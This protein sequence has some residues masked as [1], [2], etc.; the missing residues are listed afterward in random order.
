[1]S[2]SD[3]GATL[4]RRAGIVAAGTLL[5][6]LLGALRDAVI[7]ARFPLVQTDAFVVA[8]TIP[9]ALRQVLGEGAMSAAVVPLVTEAKERRGRDAARDLAGALVGTLGGAAIVVSG[10]GM[11]VAP[12][13]VALYAGGYLE[14]PARFEMAVRLTR[15]LF[16]YLAL[17]SVG[18][19][20][21]GVL[22][23]VGRFGLPA[24]APALLN[25]SLIGAPWLFAPLAVVF[26]GPKVLSL[27]LGALLG[28]CLQVLVLGVGAVRGG[29]VGRV[30]IALGEPVVREAFSRL[31]PLALGLGVYQLNLV[32]SRLLASFLPEGS[33][34]YLYY[35][36][37]LVEVPQ[38]MLA[39]AVAAAS[40]PTLSS[41]GSRGEHEE[42]LRVLRW[43]LRTTWFLALPAAALLFALAEP[44]VA[45][46]FG[47]GHFGSDAIAMTARSLRWQAL[48]VLAVATVRTV[49]PAFHA[50]GE[51]RLPVWASG[52][53]LLVFVAVAV[54]TMGALGHEGIALG[55]SVAA[56]AQLGV[57]LT[58]LRRSVGPLGGRELLGSLGRSLLASVVAAGGAWWVV[59]DEPWALGASG[60]AAMR[61]LGAG[62]LAVLLYLAVARVLRM[63]E[64]GEAWAALSR[65]GGS[66]DGT[67]AA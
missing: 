26:G 60:A 20:V 36:Q 8:F 3:R 50:V 37:R 18:A 13:L 57:L 46:V 40:L 38:G 49:V 30:R 25:L 16:P 4:G 51:T 11:L 32:A 35:G 29:W 54:G 6:R 55:A 42:A 2:E 33:Q 7:A 64:L 43:G 27:A 22:H 23:T 17:A 47:R 5:S 10:L 65:R 34:S 39:L 45:V 21:S 9:N 44:A 1:M 24:T 67:G 41:L 14:D 19:V 15:W 61:L 28:G 53:N 63:R 48:G 52:V 12:G 58:A 56:V 59:R 31:L 62:V 66:G